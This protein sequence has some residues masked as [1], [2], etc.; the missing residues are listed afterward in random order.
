[1]CGRYTLHGPV[2]RYQD[3][4]DALNWADFSDR[5]NI[6]PAASVPVIRQSPEGQRVVDLLKWGLVP[7]W[8]K[9]PSLGAKLNNARGETVSEK[10][11]F[12]D[13]FK[14]RRC[15]VPA[16]GFYEWKTEGK[17]KQ[18]YFI[19]YKSEEPLAMGGLW[20]SWR[21][22][23]G[24]IL[25]TFCIITTGPNAVMEPIHDRMPVL[26][27]PKDFARWLSPEVEGSR[28]MELIAP[29][30]ADAMEAWPV[31][32]AVSRSASDG[33]ELIEPLKED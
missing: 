3:Y 9:D 33:P 27:Q 4:F 25:R 13:A 22:E 7:H 32:K 8:S 20:E 26:I 21:D 12:R 16:S 5:F 24:K 28:L 29:A 30:P 15:L 31:S 18:P 2:S 17:A 19:H 10:P 14:R 6:A 1:M 23:E 11:S